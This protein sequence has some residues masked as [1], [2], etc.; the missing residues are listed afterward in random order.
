VLAR[1]FGLS[2]FEWYHPAA[3]E[4]SAAQLA[5]ATV[6]P[7][8]IGLCNGRPFLM[9]AGL[10]L[11]GLTTRWIEPRSHLA[12]YF[13]AQHYFIAAVIKAAG[14]GGADVTVRTEGGEWRGHIVQ[15]VANNIRHYLGGMAELSPHATIDDGLL[16]LWLLSGSNLGDSL[17]QAFGLMAGR[18]LT[19]SDV[20]RVTGQRIVIEAEFPLAIQRDGDPDGEAM[21]AE[22]EVVPGALRMIIPEKARKLLKN[23]YNSGALSNQPNEAS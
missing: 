20:Y 15:A 13:S 6:H 21:H 11:D 19:S 5:N 3:L 10:G 23:G 14:W 9:W 1:D 17:R 4:K 12:K 18:H 16:D 8:D 22:I 7:M 2:L